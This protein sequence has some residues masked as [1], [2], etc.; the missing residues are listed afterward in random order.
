MTVDVLSW[1]I[2]DEV[3][4]QDS[5]KLLRDEAL[6]R[7]GGLDPSSSACE[8]AF[9][10]VTRDAGGF[11]LSFLTPKVNVSNEKLT[12]LT[13]G[14]NYRQDI[15]RFGQLTFQGSWNNMLKHHFKQYDTTPT[16]NLLTNPYWSTEFRN[17]GNASVTWNIARASTTIY[18]NFRDK[19]PNYLATLAPAG[20]LTPGAG[21]L[22]SWT[23]FNLNFGYHVSDRIQLS[24]TVDNLFDRMPPV[25][26]SYSGL[27]YQP[28]NYLNYNI[29][30]RSYIM[31]MAYRFGK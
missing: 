8:V 3:T 30:G 25:D 1:D 24:A 12:A 18:T 23:L 27:D 26:R 28:Y 10:Q 15:G 4:Q 16:I 2:D 21:K 7:T 11:L 5:D 22:K 31:E 9:S 13:L 19:S 6:C 20:Y 29:Y 17:S 14:L